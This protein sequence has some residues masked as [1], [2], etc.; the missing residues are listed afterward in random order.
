MRQVNPK[1][2]FYQQAA[3]EGLNTRL[4]AAG[5]HARLNQDNACKV[6]KKYFDDLELSLAVE[7]KTADV[8]QPQTIWLEIAEFIQ[9]E[10]NHILNDGYTRLLNRLTRIY[11]RG[12][13]QQGNLAFAATAANYADVIEIVSQAHP[14][15]DYSEVVGHLLHY[16]NQLYKGREKSWL[17][18]FEHLLS[19]SDS[20]RPIQYLKEHHLKDIKQWIEEGVDNLFQIRDD[21][22]LLHSAKIAE[23]AETE[24]LIEQT[25]RKLARNHAK[26]VPIT[27]SNDQ[28]FLKTLTEERDLLISDLESREELVELLE[29]NIQEFEDKLYATRRA[30]VIRLV[31]D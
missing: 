18:I 8:T 25:R 27:W 13:Q 12:L 23:L 16:M 29:N 2:R 11:T 5:E 3:P 30:C 21:Q 17:R 31:R 24:Q 7:G 22:V 10:K 1:N 15:Y 28:T 26:V 9:A 14:S 6:L 20:I 4:A 19:M